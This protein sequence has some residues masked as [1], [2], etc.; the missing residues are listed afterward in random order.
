MKP[1]GEEN[2]P[3]FWDTEDS[4]PKAQKELASHEAKKKKNHNFYFYTKIHFVNYKIQQAS[5][6]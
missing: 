2:F 5:R 6:K 3:S 1:L 4:L